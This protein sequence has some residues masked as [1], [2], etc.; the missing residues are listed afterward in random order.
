MEITVVLAAVMA[1]LLVPTLEFTRVTPIVPMVLMVLAAVC[2]FPYMEVY[3]GYLQSL[4]RLSISCITLL[5]AARIYLEIQSTLISGVL[6]IALTGFVAEYLSVWMIATFQHG[7]FN[8]IKKFW[9]YILCCSRLKKDKFAGGCVTLYLN[10]A[11]SVV[12]LGVAMVACLMIL[13]IGV[14][15]SP[16]ISALES[17]S[18][19]SS[20]HSALFTINSL[21]EDVD[22]GE[23]SSIMLGNA[24]SSIRDKLY[25][26]EDLAIKKLRCSAGDWEWKQGS[27]DVVPQTHKFEVADT[28]AW[29][30]GIAQEQTES[31]SFRI[32]STFLGLSCFSV[33]LLF[34]AQAIQKAVG[35]A[36]KD[37]LQNLSQYD[38]TTQLFNKTAPPYYNIL[39]EE[40]SSHHGSWLGCLSQ[41]LWHNNSMMKRSDHARC[42]GKKKT[43]LAPHA[44]MAVESLDLEAAADHLIH[45]YQMKRDH[46]DVRRNGNIDR[47]QFVDRAVSDW[48]S[49]V[50]KHNA[51]SVAPI[52]MGAMFVLPSQ[53]PNLPPIKGTTVLEGVATNRFDAWKVDGTKLDLLV[54]RMK[55]KELADMKKAEKRSTRRRKRRSFVDEGFAFSDMHGGQDSGPG[56]LRRQNSAPASTTSTALSHLAHRVTN[57]NLVARRNRLV[58]Q[59]KEKKDEEDEVHTER[60]KL[61][62]SITSVQ[63]E[64]MDKPLGPHLGFTDSFSS[65][66]SVSEE[67]RVPS[68]E[69]GWEDTFGG[70]RIGLSHLPWDD[71]NAYHTPLDSVKLDVLQFE[72][73]Q[74]KQLITEVLRT[75]APLPAAVPTVAPKPA[76]KRM[77]SKKHRGARLSTF[78]R[79]VAG[80]VCEESL[81]PTVIAE[82][83]SLVLDGYHTHPQY[84]N[85]YHGADVCHTIWR[86][87]RLIGAHHLFDPVELFAQ[88]VA[89]LGHDLGHPGLNNNYLVSNYHTLAMS[90]HDESPLENMHCRELFKIINRPGGDSDVFRGLGI[91]G[92]AESREIVVKCILSTDMAFHSMQVTKLSELV[93]KVTTPAYAAALNDLPTYSRFGPNGHPALAF[94]DDVDTRRS[95]LEVLVHT[96]DINNP[97]KPRTQAIA[98]TDRVVAEF[99]AQGDRERSENVPISPMCDR[100]RL[101]LTSMQLGFMD[102]VVAPLFTK[103]VALFPTLITHAL[104]LFGNYSR[105]AKLKEAE[106]FKAA[107]VE[108]TKSVA[109]LHR[110]TSD[111][112]VL[113]AGN[114]VPVKPG[115]P[116]AVE[117]LRSRRNSLGLGF[118][119]ASNPQLPQSSTP[120]PFHCINTSGFAPVTLTNLRRSKSWSPSSSGLNEESTQEGTSNTNQTRGLFASRVMRM[121]NA[122]RIDR[123]STTSSKKRKGSN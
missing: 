89:A 1:L 102:F 28:T 52:D 67:T 70:E 11:G 48:I 99:C 101:D 94:L 96:A 23:I 38:N 19:I 120:A 47:G 75:T 21:C 39:S 49:S 10:S 15:R 61:L 110:Q 85:A 74:L 7:K 27:W 90:Y 103:V 16:K 36:T 35:K 57:P 106:L 58:A 51:P 62:L 32:F 31:F 13:S 76:P 20:L 97:L 2:I 79:R 78:K 86:F 64:N 12:A 37:T 4:A 5:E 24:L 88:L 84:H 43:D 107:A 6:I 25:H 18:S 82:F 66:G 45:L 119:T 14:L 92:R 3:H 29:V 118:F 17:A 40:A 117:G 95:V 114:V 72:M 55:S 59:R 46:H 22:D 41:S 105:F 80:A 60:S 53:N 81:S 50:F 121:L 109:L 116:P 111:G 112:T 100:N 73:P 93:G 71:S 77:L 104:Y 30:S 122:I 98:W 91:H 56:L 44:D 34:G 83:V 115:I 26:H 63:S 69:I 108:A 68:F 9:Y 123:S 54:E 8:K 65:V 87:Q 42:F 33:C 113:R